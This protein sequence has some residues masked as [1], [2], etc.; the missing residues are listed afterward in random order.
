MELK[1]NFVELIDY[2]PI[3]D[4]PK[5][6]SITCPSSNIDSEHGSGRAMYRKS[7]DTAAKTVVL[8]RDKKGEICFVLVAVLLIAQD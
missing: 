1:F 3:D 8:V 4:R 7:L 2:W 5:R 6:L